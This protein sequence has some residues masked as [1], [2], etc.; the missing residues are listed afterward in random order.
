MRPI[1]FAFA[2]LNTLTACVVDFA[3]TDPISDIQARATVAAVVLQMTANAPTATRTATA[4]ATRTPTR[5]STPTNTATNTPTPTLT[6]TATPTPTSTPDALATL[7]A[8]ATMTQI[9]LDIAEAAREA[10]RQKTVKALWS[11]VP[12]VFGLLFLFILLVLFF[13]GGYKAAQHY[14]GSHD[15]HVK[16]L[17]DGRAIILLDPKMI[18]QVID[19]PQLPAPAQ[20]VTN[21]EREQL[22]QPLHVV[23]AQQEYIL[24][25]G[26]AIE[27]RIDERRRAALEFL[28]K[29]IQ[30]V[31]GESER[32]PTDTVLKMGGGEWQR[33]K[34]MLRRWLGKREGKKG[35][36]CIHPDYA[37]LGALRQAVSERRIT[38][39]SAQSASAELKA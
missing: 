14:F 31:G 29:A 36:W 11:Y 1:L 5:T 21:A 17:A 35:T 8:Q 28:D 12:T 34:D 23:T 10:E 4:T 15:Y 33:H 18:A 22:Q 25:R 32:L 20:V 7:S 16:H 27:S 9:R 3:P 26:K 30:A 24:L 38:P 6:A 37:T 19:R 13:I 2:L 39:L